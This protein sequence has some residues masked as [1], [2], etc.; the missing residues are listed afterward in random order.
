MCVCYWT[1]VRDCYFI[2]HFHILESLAGWN[3]FR[4]SHRQLH[5]HSG[6]NNNNRG[7][8]ECC[9]WVVFSTRAQIDRAELRAGNANHG[10]LFYGPLSEDWWNLRVGGKSC[11]HFGLFLDEIL[12]NLLLA[13][14]CSWARA[15][16]TKAN[17][18]KLVKSA[19]LWRS[20]RM[21]WQD[22]RRI[23]IE[24]APQCRSEMTRRRFVQVEQ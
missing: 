10:T 22:F 9:V 20:G 4:I 2:P 23:I 12:E 11:T 5:R 24:F 21:V 16:P 1:G 14:P 7:L 8:L 6:S 13:D 19:R 17:R 15:R 18:H 3:P